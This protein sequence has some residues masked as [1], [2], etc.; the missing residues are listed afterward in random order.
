MACLARAWTTV[1]PLALGERL[2]SR[3]GPGW[4]APGDGAGRDRPG[5]E[6]DGHTPWAARLERKRTGP[7]AW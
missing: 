7:P 4:V 2:A 1:S 5:G 3:P 6:R